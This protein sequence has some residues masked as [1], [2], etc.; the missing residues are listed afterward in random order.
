MTVALLKPYHGGG[1]GWGGIAFGGGPGNAERR[2][3]Y[4]D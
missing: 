3:I 1:G 2:T 4:Y